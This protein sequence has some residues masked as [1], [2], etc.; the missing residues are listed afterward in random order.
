MRD[1]QTN[2]YTPN[3]WETVNCPV[4]NS[5]KH[6]IYEKFGSKLQYTYVLCQNCSLIYTNPRPKYNQDFI[7]SC[8]SSYYQYAENLTLKDLESIKE[9]SLPLFEKEFAHLMNFDKTRSAVLDIGSG[10]G[11]F[12]LAAKPYY[13]TL[14]GLDVSE[15]MAKFVE[16]TIGVPIFITQFE[17]YHPAIKF[18]LIHMSHVIEHIPNP[19]L[20]VRHA[21]N[22]LDD[23]GILVINV[24]N[25]MGLSYRIKHL[26]YKL[27]LKKQFSSSWN[28]PQRTPDHLYE[29]T[30][31]SFKYLINNNGLKIIDFY[32]YSRKDPSADKNLIS[33][34]T[35]RFFYWG[36]NLTFILKKQ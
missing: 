31:K 20:W 17:E 25:K 32:T 34:L 1:S 36:S 35:N 19:N 7:D 12:L 2:I 8:Y 4:C 24:P 16:N 33:K 29:P 3:E 30:I 26:F 15:Q 28:D 27:R 6:T 18:S 11:T 5:S 10:M 14:I 13:E 9:S 21:K 22:L 23:D